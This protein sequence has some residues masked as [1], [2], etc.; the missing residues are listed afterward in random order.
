MT[1]LRTTRIPITEL[2]LSVIEN[3]VQNLLPVPMRSPVQCKVA[4]T[5]NVPLSGFQTIDGIYCGDGSVVLVWKNTDPVDNGAWIVRSGAWE[6]A[7]DAP[8]QSAV[9]GQMAPITVRPMLGQLL[10]FRVGI[11]STYGGKY[12]WVTSSGASIPGQTAVTIEELGD[13]LYAWHFARA[14][15]DIVDDLNRRNQPIFLQSL[16]DLSELTDA[17]IYKTLELLY[18]QGSAGSMDGA[19]DR[20]E[21]LSKHYLKAYENELQSAT[22]RL[23]DGG[24]VRG[25]TR[26]VIRG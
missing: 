17:K 20:N 2:D 6:R 19:P 21:R 10:T 5:G 24:R 1:V 3:N 22:L 4:T 25:R 14:E 11:G 9:V 12:F 13:S 23:V 8:S 18:R 15:K 7:T 16:K 26:R